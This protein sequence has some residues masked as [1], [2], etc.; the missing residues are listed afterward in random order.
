MTDSALFRATVA[1]QRYRAAIAAHEDTEPSL[2]QYLAAIDYV[3][4][5]SRDKLESLKMAVDVAGA[6]R[7]FQ[8]FG[9]TINEA[10]GGI[11]SAFQLGQKVATEQSASLFFPSAANYLGQIAGVLAEL[12]K[13]SDTVK[14]EI[15]GISAAFKKG[16][17][18][19]LLDE[20]SKVQQLIEQLKTS[21]GD[22]KSQ[23][24]S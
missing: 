8:A 22:V 12:K 4:P 7:A 9:K 16:D 24:S 18:Q 5:A 3:D 1:L 21:I 14:T 13:A 10:F 2:R 11:E 6:D 19:S 20:A 17:A 15:A 23:L